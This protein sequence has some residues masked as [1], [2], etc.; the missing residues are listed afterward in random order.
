MSVSTYQTISTDDVLAG[1]YHIEKRLGSGNM[2]E[3][4]QALDLEQGRKVAIKRIHPHLVSDGD[5]IQRFQ[6][7]ARA[8]S[9]LHHPGIVKFHDF[10][11]EDGFYFIVINYLDGQT[12]EEKLEDAKRK[13]K[14]VPL[15]ETRSI[16]LQLC[17][18][19]AYAHRRGIVHRDLK[20]ANVMISPQG[21]AVV[22]D[23]GIAK[24]LDGEQL[25]GDG[26]SPGTPGYMSPEMIRG[27]AID[28]RADIYTVGI[29][30]YEM[31]T[32]RRPFQR[33][34]RYDTMHSHLFDMAPDVRKFSPNVPHELAIL[35]TQALAK[36]PDARFQT[37]EELA[38]ALRDVEIVSTGEQPWRNGSSQ[39]T[40][41]VPEPPAPP[42]FNF[43]PVE[44]PHAAA[45][46]PVPS[47]DLTEPLA[48]T[49]PAL[50]L[51][52]KR[53]FATPRNVFSRPPTSLVGIGFVVLFIC[54][55][56]TAGAI[57]ATNQWPN[58]DENVAGE[59]TLVSTSTSPR[60]SGELLPLLSP[61]AGQSPLF[62]EGETESGTTPTLAPTPTASATRW[63]AAATPTPTSPGAP[64]SQESATATPSRTPTTLPTTQPATPTPT[65]TK[66]SVPSSPTSTAPPPTKTAL[67][68]TPQPTATPQT[69][70]TSTPEIGA[71][72]IF[73]PGPTAT[74]TPW[75]EPNPTKKIKSGED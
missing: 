6:R 50:P 12:L 14:V 52:P 46:L 24:L 59:P 48:A 15:E 7:E 21:H 20:P 71:T 66:N 27:R 16:V 63:V 29:I 1:R 34:S 61:E 31:V 67:P 30:L 41:P 13:R 11:V 45:A 38:E 53:T 47:S 39:G 22:M 23:F 56:A 19:L 18:A 42:P 60:L 62:A 70:P 37:A 25:T 64:G 36:D 8:L 69:L 33:N 10:Y 49:E 32:G 54:I 68:P 17:D 28:G 57:W 3:V 74:A 58:G 35:I 5:A 72:L 75:I 73:T 2:G 9:R 4:Y 65:K 40:P 26:L 44:P 51:L 43:F 55:L